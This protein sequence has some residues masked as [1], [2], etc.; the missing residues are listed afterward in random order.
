MR[1]QQTRLAVTLWRPW[2]HSSTSPEGTA[3]PL[4]PEEMNSLSRVLSARDLIQPS[5]T[6]T[7]SRSNPWDSAEISLPL[8]G[9]SAPS[10]GV[11]GVGRKPSSMS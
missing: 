1:A 8:G 2:A 5:I 4:P 6:G 11:P 3:M 10:H 9:G 7:S